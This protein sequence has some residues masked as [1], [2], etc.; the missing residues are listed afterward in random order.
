MIAEQHVSINTAKLLKQ[1]GFN[2]PCKTVYIDASGWDGKG[3]VQDGQSRWDVPT[4]SLAARWLREKHGIHIAVTP[5]N[6]AWYWELR[7]TNGAF[8]AGSAQHNPTSPD[9]EEAIE[10]GLKEALEIIIKNKRQ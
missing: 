4:Q 9:Y 8:I 6:K 7:T 10:A 3:D 2:E 1:A 5:S